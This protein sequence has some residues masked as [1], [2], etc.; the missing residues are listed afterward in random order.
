M[1]L[2]E[3]SMDSQSLHPLN[4]LLVSGPIFF[5]IVITSL[6]PSSPPDYK[7]PILCLREGLVIISPF[8]LS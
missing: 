6:P 1:Y 2:L 3:E 7:E 4:L 5:L 8:F